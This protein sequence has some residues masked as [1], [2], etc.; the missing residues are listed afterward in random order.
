VAPIKAA[1]VDIVDA[2]T[3]ATVSK[4]QTGKAGINTVIGYTQ[5][6]IYLVAIGKSPPPGLWK[7]ETSS[8]KLSRVSS[9]RVDWEVVDETAAWG[10]HTTPDSVSSVW[11][12]DLSTGVVTQVGAASENLVYVVGFVGPGVLVVNG[13]GPFTAAF[14]INA[15]GSSL[16]VRI[17]A[18]LVGAGLSPRSFQDGKLLLLA[19]S[20]GLVAYVPDRGF[21]V[22]VAAPDLSRVLGHCA[23]A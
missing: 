10:I 20:V 16:S 17:P 12:L 15:D 5:T 14:L 18:A 22:V 6:A 7:I 21:Q 2:H 8:W 19:F 9:A 13:D 11:R 1:T 23:V 3:G 4:I